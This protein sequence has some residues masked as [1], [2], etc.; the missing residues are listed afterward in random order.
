M[1]MKTWATIVLLLL[2]ASAFAAGA[3]KQRTVQITLI[4]NNEKHIGVY[5]PGTKPLPIAESPPGIACFLFGPHFD[6]MQ[7]S[8]QDK[9]VQTLNTIGAV[10]LCGIRAPA[11][12]LIYHT[13]ETMEQSSLVMKCVV[14][15]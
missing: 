6:E 13:G 11:V 7:M 1:G 12:A 14:E 10:A 9:Q 3:E 8:C 5:H 4:F 15:Q 2:S